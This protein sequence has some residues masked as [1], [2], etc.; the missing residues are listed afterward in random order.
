MAAGSDDDW[1]AVADA[2]L[3]EGLG[4]LPK[5]DADALAF[6]G[7]AVILNRLGGI[8]PFPATDRTRAMLA[9]RQVGGWQHAS[10]ADIPDLTLIGFLTLVEARRAMLAG[11]G[12][13]GVLGVGE[14]TR[15]L[16][17]AQN[18]AP[19]PERIVGGDG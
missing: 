1:P 19:E 6:T 18:Y 4:D 15:D 9:S 7:W 14:A 12:L 10:M 16:P 13:A 2:T 11:E 5:A 17:A 8:P 3:R